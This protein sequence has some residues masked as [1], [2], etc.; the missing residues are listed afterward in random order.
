M[1]QIRCDGEFM[2]A[3]AKL[4]VQDEPEPKLSVQVRY[5]SDLLGVNATQPAS[6]DM[7][8]EGHGS[9]MDGTIRIRQAED[10]LLT[11]LR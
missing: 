2:P 9:I 1:T 11:L 4:S 5:P 3:R 10:E 7:G 6:I 8:G